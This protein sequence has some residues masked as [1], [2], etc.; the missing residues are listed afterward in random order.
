MD[1]QRKFSRLQFSADATLEIEGPEAP[2][3]LID[4]SVKGAMVEKPAEWEVMLGQRGRLRI[5]LDDSEV[6]MEMKVEVARVTE[7]RLGLRCVSIDVDSLTHLRRLLELNLG[8]PALVEREL[9]DL[10]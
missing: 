2:A 9:S 4:I 7:D 8:D 1:E 6:N 3:P 10:E 5:H